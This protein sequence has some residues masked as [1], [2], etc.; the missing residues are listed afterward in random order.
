MQKFE[1]VLVCGQKVYRSDEDDDEEDD[2]DKFDINKS[3]SCLDW[4]V[5]GG[6]GGGGDGGGGVD[7]DGDDES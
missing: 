4:G 2:D 5:S 7:V 6:G 3:D 1:L